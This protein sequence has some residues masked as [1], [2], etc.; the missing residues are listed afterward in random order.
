MKKTLPDDSY[1]LH[2]DLYQLNMIETY[3]RRGID[4]KKAIFEVFFRD[5]PFDNGYAIFAGLERLVSYINKLKFTETDLEY[6]RDEVGYKDDFIDYLRNFKFTATIRSVVEGEVVFNKEPLIQVEGPLVD[7]Q[8]VET[9]I[10]NIVNYQTLIATKAARIRS[11]VGNDALMEF[12]TRRAQELDAAIW[13]TRAAYIGGFDATSNVRAGKIFGI[14]ASGTHA[15][16]LVQA[17]RNDYEAFKAY[18][19][20][21]KDCVFLVDTYDTLKSGV[22]NAIRVAKEMG[23]KIN[24]LGVRIDSGDMA[25]ISKRVRE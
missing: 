11:V 3:W 2:T 20:T 10:L 15:H 25:Y 16:A 6:L 8:L 23:D 21:H 4:Q 14:P 24:F 22:P 7:C 19:T 5:L 9:A 17:Y 1:T 12:G 13:G 18:A